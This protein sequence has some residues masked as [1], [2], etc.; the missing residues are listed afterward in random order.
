MMV[1]MSKDWHRRM[2]GQ[3]EPYFDEESGE[4]RAIHINFQAKQRKKVV[5]Q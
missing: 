5:L 2:V 3:P 4:A 1:V